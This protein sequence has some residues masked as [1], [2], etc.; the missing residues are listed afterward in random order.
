MSS[1]K[2]SK[3]RDD[4]TSA[5]SSAK[6]FGP[7]PKPKTKQKRE[8]RVKRVF[9]TYPD[10]TVSSLTRISRLDC[11][12][13]G[14]DVLYGPHGMLRRVWNFPTIFSEYALYDSTLANGYCCCES[15]L[16]AIGVDFNTS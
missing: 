3:K 11:T 10:V 12:R 13:E 2:S 15:L 16:R 9:T 14:E 5:K 7:E 6:V 8:P 4:R 1:K